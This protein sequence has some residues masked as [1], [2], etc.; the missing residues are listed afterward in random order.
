[1]TLAGGFAGGRAGRQLRQQEGGRSFANNILALLPAAGL[2]KKKKKSGSLLLDFYLFFNPE[3]WMFS[4]R[5][6]TYWSSF[7]K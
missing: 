6:L 1:M 3:L 5:R 4:H 2:V 7:K